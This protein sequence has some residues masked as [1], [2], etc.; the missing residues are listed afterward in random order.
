MLF[1]C[2]FMA[3]ACILGTAPIAVHRVSAAGELVISGSGSIPWSIT[4][5]KPGDSGTQ[6]VTVKNNSGE[7]AEL[8]IWVSNIVN[9]EGTGTEFEAEPGDEGELAAYLTLEAVSTRISTNITMPAL[10]T[11]LP[12]S[13]SDPNYIMVLSMNANETVSISW[14]WELLADTGNIVQGDSLSFDINYLLEGLEATTTTTYYYY[15]I[16]DYDNTYD[17]F[18]FD[19]YSY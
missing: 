13:A 5:I 17:Y 19:L 7:Q 15:F 4:N 11:E 12:Q 16:I 1:I 6:A 3:V 8:T 10:I 18:N 14:D 9:I 2:S